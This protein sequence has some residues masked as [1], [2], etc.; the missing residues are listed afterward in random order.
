MDRFNLKF[1]GELLPG[2]DPARVQSLFAQ[3]FH[4]DD[5]ERAA[6][7]FSGQEITLR[8]NL[9]KDEAAQVFVKLRQIGMVTY[10]E[11]I[12]E[13]DQESAPSQEPPPEPAVEATEVSAVE[14]IATPAAPPETKPKSKPIEPASLENEPVV[15]EVILT[16]DPIPATAN[17]SD[18]AA[19]E[20]PPPRRKRQPGAPNFFEL[21]LSERASTADPDPRNATMARAP[22]FAAA[23]ALLAFLLVGARFWSQS[24]VD[25][26]T[27]LGLASI[28][29]RQQPVVQVDNTLYWHDRAGIETRTLDL[30]KLNLTPLL[31]FDFFGDGRLLLQRGAHQGDNAQLMDGLLG[32]ADNARADLLRCSGQGLECETLAQVH[33]D[34][35]YVVDR[36]TNTVIL[37]SPER[38]VLE[39]LDVNGK[40]LA[41]RPMALT[42]PV[43]L[44]LQEG[45]L[46][47]TQGDSDAVEVLKPDDRDFGTSLDSIDLKVEGASLS[48]HIFPGDLRYSDERWWV[49][50]QSRDQSTA[51]LYLFDSRWRFLEALQLPG[52][53]LPVQLLRWSAKILATDPVNSQI[54]RFDAAARPEKPFLS[55]AV[56]TALQEQQADLDLSQS[57]QALILVMLFGV[58]AGMLAFSILQSMRE[59]IYTAPGDEN[60]AGF[61]INSED[62]EWLAPANNSDKRMRQIGYGLAGGAVIALIG[63]FIIGVS[64]WAMLALSLILVGVGGVYF[65]LQRACQCHLGILDDRL[66]VVDHTNTYRVGSGPK[67]QYLHNYVMIDDVIVYLGNRLVHQFADEPL[68]S[69]FQPLFTTGIKVDRA[70]LRVKLIQRR[71]PML[72]GIAG[73]AVAVIC[74]GFLVAV[75]G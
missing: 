36:R 69:R 56:A 45:I 16:S 29:A 37:A 23:I 25:Q 53:A 12:Q 27:D 24:Q 15:E 22:L 7:F 6:R 49:I 55:D 19:A 39:K 8:R 75:T 18:E 35:S 63:S 64:I 3:A 71:H 44:R 42:A 1:R 4:I 34:S 14:P 41:T 62:I 51:G 67:I 52:G 28:D 21:R 54:H 13:A 30:Q 20:P 68:Q 9:S 5:P 47:L 58:A 73:M 60:E 40:L 32:Q 31:Y 10:T 17:V 50:M 65:G 43:H 46:Y 74:S 33:R 70:T 2:H 72:L 66:I 26:T 38:D 61:D 11:K 48:G 57:L 59:R